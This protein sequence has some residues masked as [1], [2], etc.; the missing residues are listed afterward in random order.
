MRNNPL[1]Y[2]TASMV[3]SYAC[4][5]KYYYQYIEGWTLV[6]P[7]ASTVFGSIIHESIAAEFLD[8]TTAK[9]Y[10]LE[11]WD[12]IGVL[13]YSRYDSK[14]SLRDIG[15]ALIDK[16]ETTEILQR[17]VAVEKPYQ[18]VLPDSTTF[19]GKIDLIYYDGK[20]EIILDWKTANSSFID[21]R[22]DLDDQ[23]TAYSM[24]SGIKDVC[25]G[26][27]LKKKNPDV[28]FHHSAINEKDWQEYQAKVMKIVMD[29]EDGFFYKNPSIYCGFCDFEPLCR[30]Q[31]NRI[32]IELKQVPII[33]RYKNLECEMADF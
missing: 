27:L 13:S 33:D 14:E 29:I 3:Q 17:V 30:N 15:L 9:E 8:S 7:K 28:Q 11:K 21:S 6:V 31:E 25:Y 20:N 19:K 26:V 2:I 10:F 5:R 1:G 22:P 16:L 12:A 24:L 23:L 4:P 32:D 18:T